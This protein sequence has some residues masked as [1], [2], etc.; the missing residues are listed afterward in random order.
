[1]LQE[2]A[3]YGEPVDVCA[4]RRARASTPATSTPSSPAGRSRRATAHLLAFVRTR[5]CS[6]APRRDLT[7][8]RRCSPTHGCGVLV[9]W[10][11]STGEPGRPG[12]RVLPRVRRGARGPGDRVGGRRAV[13]LP[14][15]ADRLD[16]LEIEPGSGDGPA[17]PAGGARSTATASAS[18]GDVVV[19]PPA[20]CTFSAAISRPANA[21]VASGARR[22]RDRHR[23]CITRRAPL[24]RGTCGAQHGT[25]HWRARTLRVRP[26]RQRPGA[27]PSVL[28]RAAF[29][30]ERVRRARLGAHGAIAQLGER[31]LCKQEVAGSIPA[32]SILRRRGVDG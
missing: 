7:R 11:R 32:G 12:A 13:R 9:R 1:M 30:R 28:R 10:R 24:R 3:E 27:H 25:C 17:E 18:S 14:A 5:R 15:R 26:G 21:S 16:R 22:S 31:L 8:S 29:C 4:G 23:P 6:R 2:P 20:S 19:L